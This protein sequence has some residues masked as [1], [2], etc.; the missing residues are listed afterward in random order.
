MEL[1]TEAEGLAVAEVVLEDAVVVA[2]YADVSAGSAGF[3]AVELQPVLA[4]TTAVARTTSERCFMSFLHLKLDAKVI[5][6]YR[7]MWIIKQYYGGRI[8]FV[9]A[10]LGFNA[11]LWL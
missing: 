2:E 1:D 9:I 5:P 4:R 6:T 7:L 11:P 10:K 8:V 3:S